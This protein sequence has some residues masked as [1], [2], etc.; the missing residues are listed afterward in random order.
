MKIASSEID[1]LGV[2]IKNRKVKL[3]EH[4]IKKIVNF[5]EDLQATK[6]L[7]SFLGILNFGRDY[8][9]NLGKLLSPLYSK[10]SCYGEKRFREADWQLIRTIKQMVQNLPDL[11][12]PLPNAFIII[13]TDGCMQ[14]WGAICKWKKLRFDPRN[15]ETVCAYASGKFS[16][17]K[18]SIDAEIHA[19][20][21]GLT[22]FKI[23]YLDKREVLLRTDCDAIIKFFNKTSQNKPSRVRWLGFIDF[24]TNTGVE[25]I[26]EHIDA[27]NNILADSLSRLVNCLQVEEWTPGPTTQV[28]LN[29]LQEVDKAPKEVQTQAHLVILSK[30]NIRVSSTSQG[31]GL[32]VKLSPNDSLLLPSWKDSSKRLL[33]KST[34][35]TTF[36]A[37]KQNSAE[38]VPPETTTTQTY[39]SSYASASRKLKR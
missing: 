4:F 39:Y 17:L 7:R 24:C 11:E 20:M 2:T 3:Q 27:K 21:E 32:T 15:M 29:L 1:F 10:T 6:G 12:L 37:A 26:F 22:A 30:L 14:G 25:V 28:C 31:L 5:N 38:I 34:F 8:I 13:E 36:L 23:H 9:P 18:I 16:P 33:M 19:A 35:S